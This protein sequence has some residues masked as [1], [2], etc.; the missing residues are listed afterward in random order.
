M[1]SIFG[2]MERVTKEN[3]CR[4]RCMVMEYTFGRMVVSTKEAISVIK[5][6]GRG[7]TTGQ[8]AVGLKGSGCMEKERARVNL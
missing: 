5:N 1:V 6:T 3:G 4:I 2:P 8:M 7:S